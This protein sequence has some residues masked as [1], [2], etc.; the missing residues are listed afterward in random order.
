M[1]NTTEALR[2][3]L[4]ALIRNRDEMDAEMQAMVYAENITTHKK[5]VAEISGII[6]IIEEQLD[7]LDQEEKNDIIRRRGLDL[8]EWDGSSLTDLRGCTALTRIS[9]GLSENV[10]REI[11]KGWR[12]AHD[13]ICPGCGAQA[14]EQEELGNYYC[15]DS[16][17]FELSK[18]EVNEI[19]TWRKLFHKGL[20]ETIAKWRNV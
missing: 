8:S 14:S 6:T 7:Q 5:K 19:R 16:C 4:T 20:K 2:L 18:N 17:G 3:S 10:K 9:P 1:I 12:S 15:H 11:Y 13:G